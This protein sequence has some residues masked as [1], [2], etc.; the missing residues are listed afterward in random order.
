MGAVKGLQLSRLRLPFGRRN[1]LVVRVRPGIGFPVLF[2]PPFF[3]FKP[4]FF[5]VG[6]WLGR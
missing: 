1:S 5:F 3:C 6:C 4:S 2:F